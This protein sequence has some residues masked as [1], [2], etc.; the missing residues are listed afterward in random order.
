MSGVAG[1]SGRLTRRNEGKKIKAIEKAWDLVN[2]E[3]ES[4]SP[5]R[6]ETARQIAVKDITTQIKGE[7][8]DTRNIT[9]IWRAADGKERVFTPRSAMESLGR[10]DS[11]QSDSGRS[12]IR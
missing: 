7:G 6:F 1:K 9:V 8:F 12:E 5:K 3:L 2:E 4:D 11:V 10:P